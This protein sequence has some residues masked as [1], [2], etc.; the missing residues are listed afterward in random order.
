[1]FVTS[2]GGNTWRGAALI[3]FDNWRN[4]HNTARLGLSPLKMRN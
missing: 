4:T 2:N 3:D 1:M